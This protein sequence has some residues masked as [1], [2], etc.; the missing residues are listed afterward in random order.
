MKITSIFAKLG[1]VLM[2]A[3]QCH[4]DSLE[5]LTN[6]TDTYKASVR[7]SYVTFNVLG[8]T[9]LTKTNVAGWT[10]LRGALLKQG[11]T[12]KTE[13]I[14]SLP[15]N[16]TGVRVAPIIQAPVVQHTTTDY[17]SHSSGN[18]SGSKHNGP[19]QVRSYT[20]KDGTVV[21]AH[22]RSSRN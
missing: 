13:D 5:T 3:A 4:G 21:K 20:R 19:V 6:G 1:A 15:Y 2:M 14:T 11:Y 17:S 10:S 7:L 16:G 18:S 22:T 9:S 8:K 12:I